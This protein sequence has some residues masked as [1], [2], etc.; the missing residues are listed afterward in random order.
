[1]L[2]NLLLTGGRVDGH[3]LGTERFSALVLGRDVKLRC[4]LDRLHCRARDP[5]TAEFVPNLGESVQI[6][7]VCHEGDKAR[8]RKFEPRT[9]SL[10]AVTILGPKLRPSNRVHKSNSSEVI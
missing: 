7:I 9:A 10:K 8:S 5:G 4:P 2:L 1:M 3:R 6:P